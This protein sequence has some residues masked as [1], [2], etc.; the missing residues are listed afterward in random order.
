MT[1]RIITQLWKYHHDMPNTEIGYGIKYPDLL[2][3]ALESGIISGDEYR[4][5][6][7]IYYRNHEED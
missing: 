6:E 7:E 3:A 2:N 5:Y 1:T 4:K